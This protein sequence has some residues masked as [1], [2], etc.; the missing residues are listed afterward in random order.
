MISLVG[1]EVEA[2]KNFAAPARLDVGALSPGLHFVRGRNL[3]SPQLGS[4]GA[5]KSTF[6]SD[7]PTWCLSGTTASGLRTTDLKSWLTKKRPRV[8]LTFSSDGGEV[9]LQRGPRA[10]DISINGKTVGQDAVDALDGLNHAAR[11]QAVFMGQGLPLFLDLS[12]GDKM[13]VLS[14]ALGLERWEARARAAGERG[15]GLEARAGGLE[16]EIR[17]LEA[18]R[19][20]AQDALGRARTASDAWAGGQA[21]RLEELASAA[22]ILRERARELEGLRGEADLAGDSAGLE[23]N[24]LRPG[25]ESQR[26]GLEGLRG[27]AREARA[28]A[29]AERAARYRAEEA[30]AAF[31]ERGECPACGQAVTKKD[32]ARH[33][34]ELRAEI[35]LRKTQASRHLRAQRELEA[36]I[37][38]G[39][40]LLSSLASQL[41]K[42]EDAEREADGKL[43]LL[44]RELGAAA[45]RASA[46][47][48]ALLRAQAEEDPHRQAVMDAARRLREIDAGLKE[49]GEL[50][51]RLR[52]SA[53][54]AQFWARGFREIRLGIIDDIVADLRETTAEVLEGLGLGDWQVD[55]LT[56]RETKSGATQRA[57]SAVVRSPAAPERV[58]WEVY[59]GGERQRLRLASALALSEVLLAHAGT[60]YNFRVLDE[61]T[62]G[63]SPEGRRDLVEVLGDYARQAGLKIFYIDHT[64]AEGAQFA[65]SVEVVGRPGG[66]R[67]EVA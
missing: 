52:A 33:A 10:E 29:E 64:S 20:H 44:E 51:R 2:L 49:K 25:V 5:G 7:A 6:F 59:S 35:T 22:R 62:R 19:G 57:L 56:E 53:E 46:A 43:R 37:A 26:G 67:V 28:Q 39:E 4:N 65:S 55:Y 23:A 47:E 8:K 1:I 66:A 3:V 48:E 24:L 40:A 18:A 38:E 11:C 15:R 60:G 61:P 14:D 63:L 34:A 42:A 9:A 58:R 27:E 30:L 50:L 12:P 21:S 16:G 45:S 13:G 17:G 54:R 36:K 31:D 32:A 41:R